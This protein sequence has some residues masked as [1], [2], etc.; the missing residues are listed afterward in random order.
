M[1]C[2]HCSAVN[3]E[4]AKFCASCGKNMVAVSVQDAVAT[5]P[6]LQCG[7]ECKADAKFCPKCGTT[8]SAVDSIDTVIAA[9]PIPEKATPPAM[10]S[11]SKVV[12][13]KQQPIVS[14]VTAESQS[15]PSSKP[16][17]APDT[18]KHAKLAGVI[19]GTMLPI[20]PVVLG[21]TGL[22]V[23]IAAGTIYMMNSAATMIKPQP[24]LV[25][26]KPAIPAA[27]EPAALPRLGEKQVELVVASTAQAPT[28]AN[29]V[30]TPNPE[31][32]KAPPAIVSIVPSTHTTATKPAMATAPTDKAS[33]NSMQVAIDTTLDEG[34]KCMARKKYDC[35]ISSANTVIRLDSSNARG[36]EMK[37][38][39]KEAQDR[40]LSQIDIQ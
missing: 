35:A 7:H 13:Q 4:G 14:P 24:E 16:S 22:L 36:I 11:S 32:A 8:F 40:A 10:P 33:V 3:K 37:R 20:L 21:V 5:K 38:K 19:P 17:L 18:Q 2:P 30:I 15:V 26:N 29:A 31:P 39:A 27:T 28:V 34:D 12:E 9:A 6:C 1:K 23:L 25:A